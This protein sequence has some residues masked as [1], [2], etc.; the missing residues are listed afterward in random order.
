MLQ[1]ILAELNPLDSDDEPPLKRKDLIAIL[2]RGGVTFFLD[3][4]DEVSIRDREAVMK[5]IKR[6]IEEFP[7]NH[8]V[9]SSRPENALAAFAGFHRFKIEPLQKHESFLLIKKY[10]NNGPHSEQL[11]KRLGTNELS[12]VVEFLKNPLL[13]TLLYRCYEYK[14][15]I[16]LRKPAFYRQV[17]DAL[18]DWHDATKDGYN[19]REKTSRLDLDNFHRV[20][21]ALGFI[22]ILTGKVEGDADEFLGWIRQAKT[23]C[24]ELQ[25]SESNFLE[26]A[27]KAVPVLCKEG[28][29]Y[30]W[31]H[32]S[33]AE[34][35]CAQFIVSDLKAD[36]GRVLKAIAG[37]RALQ[38]FQNVLDLLYDMDAEVFRRH[39]VEPLSSL[40]K[41]RSGLP[42][43]GLDPSIPIGSVRLRMALTFLRTIHL[44]PDFGDVMGEITKLTETPKQQHGLE[45]ATAE[46][47]FVTAS[48]YLVDT[49]PTKASRPSVMLC[50]DDPF[51]TVVNVLREKRDP[52]FVPSERLLEAGVKGALVGMKKKSSVQL[53]MTPTAQWNQRKSFDSVNNVLVRMFGG[54]VDFER[55]VSFDIRPSN[56]RIEKLTNDLLA[57]FAESTKNP[58]KAVQEV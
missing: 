18:Y 24:K 33:L 38:S 32:K 45:G 44:L 47:P 57:T 50:I 37:N 41:Q 34:Y 13:T 51:Q 4:F 15:Q 7:K 12:N 9:I 35:F 22:T 39:F 29:S 17:Y 43:A 27:T 36:Q 58:A 49:K 3:G 20:L 5:D 6:V 31:S 42:W 2:K 8:Y 1:Y 26:D 56:Q 23:Y 25:F 40:L 48:I 52:L 16:P 30:K 19:T 28:N 21:R 46:T 14:S 10:D 11:I 53:D 55:L 54:A